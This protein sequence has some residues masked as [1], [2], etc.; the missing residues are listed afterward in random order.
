MRSRNT[1]T[2]SA[3]ATGS[4]WR[5]APKATGRSTATPSTGPIRLWG[6]SSRWPR[7]R[8]AGAR[9]QLLEAPAVDPEVAA[10]EA[11]GR[12][13]VDH[14]R[15]VV[16]KEFDVVDVA[17][18]RR[19]ELR[20]KIIGFGPDDGGTWNAQHHPPHRRDCIS[21]ER[22]RR[23][24][25]LRVGGIGLRGDA[26]G[27]AL[28]RREAGISHAEIDGPLPGKHRRDANPD[29]GS[30]AFSSRGAKRRLPSLRGR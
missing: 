25:V 10:P 23:D 26:V 21:F 14:P 16:V 1:G 15:L 22:N 28:A 13:H 20:V 5:Y 7:S 9:A 11:R 30:W 12:A 17:H 2:P 6:I 29:P 3:S 18:Q 27:R 24:V 4:S 8:R 19:A